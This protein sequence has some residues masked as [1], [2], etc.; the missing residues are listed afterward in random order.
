MNF[1]LRILKMK[2]FW[3]LALSLL[4]PPAHA[5]VMTITG[6][7]VSVTADSAAKAREQA[8]EQAHTQAFQKLLNENFPEKTGPLPSPET[9]MD[10]VKNFSIDREKATSTGYTA[11]L[12]FQFYGPKVAAWISQGQSQV[13][14]QNNQ[15]NQNNLVP[16]QASAEVRILKITASYES[17]SEWQRLKKVLQDFPGGQLNVISLSSNTSLMELVYGGE[18]EKLQQYL[19][20]QGVLLSPQEG[21]WIISSNTPKLS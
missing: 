8:L 16:Q 18:V 15:N 2:L 3:I 11:S 9:L 5:Q 20:K 21:S 1:I 17:L 19:L 10:M 14:S 7:K 4:L 6:V 12:T 13:S